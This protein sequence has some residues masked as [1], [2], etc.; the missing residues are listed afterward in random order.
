MSFGGLIKDNKTSTIIIPVNADLNY[1]S[2][3]KMGYN[4]TLLIPVTVPEITKNSPLIIIPVVTKFLKL[5]YES[6]S[7]T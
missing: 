3:C 7:F 5:K 2:D 1:D 4:T 6:F